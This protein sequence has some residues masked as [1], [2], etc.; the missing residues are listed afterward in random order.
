MLAKVARIAVIELQWSS[1]RE[2]LSYGDTWS[3][4]RQWS[5]DM[6]LAATNPVNASLPAA[7]P[8]AWL[9]TV[10]PVLVG[11]VS[12]DCAQ[13]VLKQ[14]M[15]KE[16]LQRTSGNLSRAAKL[17]GVTRQAIQQMLDRYDLRA[18]CLRKQPLRLAHPPPTGTK[19][20]E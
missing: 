18:T 19:S 15:L 4:E 17:L 16:A 11:I 6:S 20:N 8:G 10:G 13:N 3:T 1:A 2:W 14:A 12:M 9:D 7:E 5:T